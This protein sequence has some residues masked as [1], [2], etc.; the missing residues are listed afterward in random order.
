MDE[1]NRVDS[2]NPPDAEESQEYLNL[3]IDERF[4]AG[5]PLGASLGNDLPLV[6]KEVPENLWDVKGGWNGAKAY[7]YD[8]V[9]WHWSGEKGQE[10]LSRAVMPALGVVRYWTRV[11]G[12]YQEM[13]RDMDSRGW[14]CFFT[15]YRGDNSWCKVRCVHTS[16][17]EVHYEG[18]HGAK[19]LRM[20]ILPNGNIVYYGGEKGDMYKL[21]TYHPSKRVNGHNVLVHY[22]WPEDG[23]RSGRRVMVRQELS[24][25]R[26]RTMAGPP[27]AEYIVKTTFPCGIV[28]EFEGHRGKERIVRC[29]RTN[30]DVGRFAGERGQERLHRI[31]RA[32]GDIELYVGVR[33]HERLNARILLH[34]VVH[35]GDA[36]F[37]TYT[38]VKDDERMV[39]M[40]STDQQVK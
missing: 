14:R 17:R 23:R 29:R 24:D 36:H 22:D 1:L 21:R 38:G 40:L 37:I 28:Q 12:Q 18:E 39:R 19:A 6:P 5:F 26:V 9:T 7:S 10:W 33:C 15:D 13:R 34:N 8:G 11:R 3:T 27:G 25:G 30:G 32:N 31:D 16:G 35:E 20:I 4:P 2:W